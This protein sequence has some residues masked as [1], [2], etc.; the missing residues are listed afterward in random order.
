MKNLKLITLG[1]LALSASNSFASP[2]DINV[3]YGDDNRKD[4]YESRDAMMVTAA[5]STAGMMPASNIKITGKTAE[6]SGRR[7]Q[8]LGICDTERFATQV[9]AASCSGFL[10][11]PD[12]FVTAGHCIKNE[13]DCKTLKWVF[14]Y[15]MSSA[16]Q[17]TINVPTTSIYSCTKIVARSF[18]VASKDDYAVIRLDRRVSGRAPLNMR[19]TGKIA[20][21]EE[22]VVIGH[23]TGLPTK[24]SDDAQVRS[25]QGKY[26]VANLDTYG[27]NSGSAVLNAKTGLVE[28][29]LVRGENDYVPNSARGCQV[30]N[31]C[32]ET[33]CRGEDV[34]YITNIT[35]I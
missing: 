6:I 7:L 15:K 16:G 25:L 30:S 4:V 9:T 1:L 11:G 10:I 19:R 33:G 27:G 35:G 21:G 18:E 29:I 23:P 20:V 22:I 2:D 5:K 31:R 13:N 28:G 8:D 14:D 3:I 17:K 12:L 26:F 34:T 24:I 32:S